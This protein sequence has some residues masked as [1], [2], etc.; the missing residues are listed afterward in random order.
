MVKYFQYLPMNFQFGVRQV[1]HHGQLTGELA[2]VDPAA[3]HVVEGAG[4]VGEQTLGEDVNEGVPV[5]GR[6][7]MDCGD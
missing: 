1:S 3:E 2:V 4:D 7:T 5:G 6:E